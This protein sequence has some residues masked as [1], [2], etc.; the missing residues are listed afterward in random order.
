MVISTSMK[1]KAAIFTIRSKTMTLSN[2]GGSK[3]GELDVAYR[4]G[5]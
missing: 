1:K 2:L 4:Y 3:Q 5:C